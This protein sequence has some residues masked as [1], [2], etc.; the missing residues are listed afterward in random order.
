MG[1]PGIRSF[2]RGFAPRAVTAAAA[3]WALTGGASG[4]DVWVVG[5]P[6]VIAAAAMSATFL[7][8]FGW[9]WPRAIRFA[10]FFVRESWLG[11]V[12]VAKRALAP[13]M[14]LA[15]G[16]VEHEIGVV[17]DLARV[18]VIN[19]SSLLPGSLVV[20]SRGGDVLVH[21]LDI[22]HADAARTIDAAEARIAAM[23]RV[24]R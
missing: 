11:G 9:S 18:A 2:A 7:P 13:R 4:W 24:E 19:T 3:W 8:P 6:A 20:D 15:P 23:L 10:A 16:F 5:V 21:V 1:L 14:P 22:G 17:P 12:D